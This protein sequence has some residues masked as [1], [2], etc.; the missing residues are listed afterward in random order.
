MEELTGHAK[1][2]K[3]MDLLEGHDRAEFLSEAV[4]VQA[5]STHSISILE[6]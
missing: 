5:A 6:G 3:V 2:N 1:S 4:L